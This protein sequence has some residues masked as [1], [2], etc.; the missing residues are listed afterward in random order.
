MRKLINAVALPSPRLPVLCQLVRLLCRSS[1]KLPRRQPAGFPRPEPK[2]DCFALS[3]FAS[4]HTTTSTCVVCARCYRQIAGCSGLQ[5][6]SSPCSG[7]C[8]R[9]ADAARKHPGP[10]AQLALSR[11]SE[12][13]LGAVSI[14]VKRVKNGVYAVWQLSRMNGTKELR[15]GAD[16]VAELLS[17]LDVTDMQCAFSQDMID[18]PTISEIRSSLK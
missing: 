6:T 14:S 15:S 8:R 2:E 4:N 11:Q 12:E 17:R 5:L 3:L 7:E 18:T 9:I 16:P 1:D 10:T 13:G